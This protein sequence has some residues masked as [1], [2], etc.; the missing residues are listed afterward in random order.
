MFNYAPYRRGQFL[1]VNK[2]LQIVPY[3]LA[4]NAAEQDY[5]KANNAFLAADDIYS[6]SSKAACNEL[7]AKL[8]EL[9]TPDASQVKPED[10]FAVAEKKAEHA[11]TTA[12]GD[13]TLSQKYLREAAMACLPVFCTF[14][15]AAFDKMVLETF[16]KGD[17]LSKTRTD[18]LQAR[19]KTGAEFKAA[20]LKYKDVFN[21]LSFMAGCE[22]GRE[23]RRAYEEANRFVSVWKQRAKQ[24]EC[25]VTIECVAIHTLPEDLKL[26]WSEAYRSLG[27]DSLQRKPAYRPFSHKELV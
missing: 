25:P 22:K 4:C 13:R 5:N 18:A 20:M 10:V 12:R 24:F 27:F 16:G 21:D 8:R 1:H 6:R 14:D 15:E 9:V 11:L 19:N 3:W 17:P 23:Y 26:V 2:D 7:K